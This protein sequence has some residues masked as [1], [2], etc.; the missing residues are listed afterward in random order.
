MVLGGAVL[1]GRVAHNQRLTHSRRASRSLYEMASL[2]SVRV[3]NQPLLSLP[4]ARAAGKRCVMRTRSLGAL[5]AW[6]NPSF[7]RLNFGP[8]GPEWVHQGMAR[9]EKEPC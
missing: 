7:F 8:E 9:I 1:L 6:R 5:C 4:T 3:A 2:S